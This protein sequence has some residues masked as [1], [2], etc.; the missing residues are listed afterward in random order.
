MSLAWT[1]KYIGKRAMD[2]GTDKSEP[3]PLCKMKRER[4]AAGCCGRAGC[5]FGG[6]IFTGRVGLDLKRVTQGKGEGEY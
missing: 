2:G 6:I 3:S 5:C 4:T 1:P